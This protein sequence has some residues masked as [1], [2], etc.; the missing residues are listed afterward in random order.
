VKNFKQ[1]I[2]PVFMAGTLL[3]SAQVRADAASDLITRYTSR[4]NQPNAIAKLNVPR[5]CFEDEKLVSILNAGVIR[6]FSDAIYEKKL[7]SLAN[8]SLEGIKGAGPSKKTFR[9]ID[10]ISEFTWA[11]DNG[12]SFSERLSGFSQIDYADTRILDYKIDSAIRDK[13]EISEIY[14]KIKIDIRG[15]SKDNLATH[16]VFVLGALASLKGKRWSLGSFELI[17]GTT[18]S[19]QRAPYFTDISEAS[20][21]AA[22]EFP[23]RRSIRDGSAISVSDLNG[24]H[25]PDI[26]VG[27]GKSFEV[28]EGRNNNSYLK[29]TDFSVLPSELNLPEGALLSADFDADNKI[30]FIGGTLKQSFVRS[31]KDNVVSAKDFLQTVKPAAGAR[32]SNPSFDSNTQIQS[33]LAVDLDSNGPIDAIGVDQRGELRYLLKNKNS[34]EFWV[35]EAPLAAVAFSF[36]QQIEATD[37]NN[38]SYSDVIVADLNLSEFS[39]LNATCMRHFSMNIFGADNTGLKIFEGSKDGLTAV[40][41]QA[42]NGTGDGVAAVAVFDYNNDGM[43]DIYVVNGL[44]SGDKRGQETAE[45][46][47]AVKRETRE[48]ISQMIGLENATGFFNFLNTFKGRITDFTDASSITKTEERPSLAGFQRNRLFRNNGDGTFTDVAYIE[49]IDSEADGYAVAV[50]DADRNGAM[51]VLLRNANP[52]EGQKKRSAMQLFKNTNPSGHGAVVFELNPVDIQK[53]LAGLTVNAVS[54]KRKQVLY[55][56]GTNNKSNSQKIIHVGTGKSGLLP[57]A[58]FKWQDGK[59]KSFKN[60]KTGYHKLH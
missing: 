41:F 12:S 50:L 46:F 44:W 20:G 52:A 38:D 7:S 60:L 40:P 21:L 25:V 49:G 53:S 16:D 58:E 43:S 30:D 28:F 39:R 34:Q 27:N 3:A 5:R 33:A 32:E 13:G 35:P 42:N 22:V 48:A 10:G 45:F 17:S 8:V 56:T 57:K 36:V 19:S 51:D 15:K 14:L 6:D 9:T 2:L 26:I 29:K 24:D 55:M 23:S 11:Q 4:I 31:F 1:N 54:G 59:T 18:V 37:L 47:V